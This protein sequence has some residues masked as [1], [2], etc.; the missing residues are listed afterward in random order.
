MTGEGDMLLDN[1]S[2]NINAHHVQIGDQNTM[3]QTESERLLSLLEKK[4]E[5]I[6]QRDRQIDELIAMLKQQMALSNSK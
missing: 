5:Q 3:V 6:Q 4:E 2:G 1:A